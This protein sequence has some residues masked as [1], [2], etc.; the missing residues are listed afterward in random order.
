MH[1]LVVGYNIILVLLGLEGGDKEFVGVTMVGGQDVLI[2]AERSDGEATSIVCVELG[3][4][5]IPNV[6]LVRSDGEKGTNIRRESCCSL[7][8]RLGIG[9]GGAESLPSMGKT[10]F[11][12]FIHGRSVLGGVIIC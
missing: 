6:N 8:G 3:Y 7:Y 5:F 9:F 10:N 4:W 11:Y 2:F 12:S 1:N